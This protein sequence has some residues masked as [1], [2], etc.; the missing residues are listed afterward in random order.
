MDV[1]KIEIKL[2]GSMYTL[3]LENKKENA[4]NTVV[5]EVYKLMQK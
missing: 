1:F 3:D 5:Y 2:C 4:K